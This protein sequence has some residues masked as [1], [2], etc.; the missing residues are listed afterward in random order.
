MIYGFQHK[1][2]ERRTG[3]RLA[4]RTRERGN[5]LVE[6]ALVLAVLL[7]MM[8][9]IIDFGRALYTYHFV[10]STARDAT[11]W[12]SVRSLNTTLPGG[13]AQ[14]GQGGNVQS[15]FASSSSLAGMG[16]DSTKITM[17]TTPIM[18]PNATPACNPPQNLP[19]C[20]VQVEVDYTYHFFMPFLPTSPVTMTSTS[21]MVITQ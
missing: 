1:V 12:A 15:T 9:A 16:L 21:Q 8:F 17:T 4:T 5:S 6:H 19:G 3:I 20:V 7:T 18:P 2:P 10:A 11:R 13:P 14:I